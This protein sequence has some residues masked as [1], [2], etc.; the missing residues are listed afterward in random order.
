MVQIRGVNKNFMRLV[1][2]RENKKVR[3]HRTA[4]P[5]ALAVFLPWGLEGAGREPSPTAK[6]ILIM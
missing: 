2:Y 1:W 5:H 4:Q 6:V 3:A